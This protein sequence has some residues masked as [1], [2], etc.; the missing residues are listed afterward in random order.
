MK[1]KVLFI[2]ASCL[3]VCNVQ[4]VEMRGGTISLTVTWDDP[5]GPTNPIPKV[6]MPPLFITQDG[7]ILTLPATSVDY[8]LVLYD[9]NGTLA[10][11]TFL[12]AGTTQVIL[13]TTLSGTY[14]IRLVADTYYYM[15]YLE[16]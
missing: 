10:Y 12:S 11:S 16:L 5:S 15:G 9:E 6:P 14:E 1:K 8:T 4:G 2:L 3:L 7:N 13:P